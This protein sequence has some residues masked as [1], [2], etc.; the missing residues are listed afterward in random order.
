M[1]LL[2][3]AV[4][5]GNLAGVARIRVGSGGIHLELI[6]D[7]GGTLKDCDDAGKDGLR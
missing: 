2:Q 1:A 3:I 6:T 5:K 7:K 4:A